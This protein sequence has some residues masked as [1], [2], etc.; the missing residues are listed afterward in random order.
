MNLCFASVSQ[1]IFDKLSHPLILCHAAAK[2]D[3]MKV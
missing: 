1:Q 3:M 2:G